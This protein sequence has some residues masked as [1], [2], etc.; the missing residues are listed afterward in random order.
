VGIEECGSGQAL[1]CPGAGVV[2]YE[3]HCSQKLWHVRVTDCGSSGAW[4]LLNWEL[5]SMEV[6]EYENCGVC[7]SHSV[8]V[9]GCAGCSLWDL[10]HLGVSLWRLVLHLFTVIG[11]VTSQRA[12]FLL[13]CIITMSWGF[14]LQNIDYSKNSFRLNHLPQRNLQKMEIPASLNTQKIKTVFAFDFFY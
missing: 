9:A 4:E 13:I 12:Y 10:Q 3:S 2:A 7:Q 8:L 6:D 1:E 14:F 5:Q 11:T